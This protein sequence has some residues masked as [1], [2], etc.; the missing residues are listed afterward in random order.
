MDTT[1]ELI[2]DIRT[3]IIRWYPFKNDADIIYI[4]KEDAIFSFL[5]E[6]CGKHARSIMLSEIDGKLV[7]EKKEHKKAEYIVSIA[8]PEQLAKPELFFEWAYKHLESDGRLIVGMNNRL[9][10]RYFCGDRDIYTSQV[11]DGI[12]DYYRAYRSPDDKFLGRSFD[13]SQIKKMISSSGFDHNKFYS[14]YSDLDNAAFIF[15]DSYKPNEELYNRIIPTYNSP[16][17]LFLE[18]ERLYSSMLDNELFHTM[19]NAFLIECSLDGAHTDALQITSS[20]DRGHGEAMITVIHDNDTVTKQAAFKE[21]EEG[22]KKLDTNIKKLKSRGVSVVE[23]KLKDGIYTMPLTK[24]ETGAK[25][26]QR[27]FWK[28]RE[29]FLQRLDEFK[30]EIYKSSDLFEGKYEFPVSENESEADRLKRQKKRKEPWE[31]EKLSLLKEG[32]VDMIPLN[33][34]FVDGKFVFFDQEF[35]LANYP[36]KAILWRVLVSIYEGTPREERVISR[37]DLF[38]RYGLDNSDTNRMHFI[39]RIVDVWLTGL[40]KEKNLFDYH[41][42]IRKDN[43]IIHA[44]RQRMNYS[45]DEYQ[46][47]FI[48]T[49]DRADSRKLILFGSGIFARKFLALYG[50]DYDIYAVIDNNKDRWGQ[51]VYPDGFEETEGIEIMPPSVLE[52]F[53]PGEYKVLICIKNFNSVMKQLDDM[54]ISE[55]SVF[56]PTKAYPVKRHPLSVE[57]VENYNNS[58]VAKGIKKYHVGYIAGVFDLYHIGHLNMFRRAKEMCDYL[59]VGVLSDEGV[60]HQKRTE[61]FVPFAE[62]IEMVKSCR[63]VDE[64]VEI[65]YM[66]ARTEDAFK[67]HHFDVQFSGSD[68][69]NDP[70]FNQY[71]KYLESHGA[72]MEFFPYTQSTSST[73]LKELIEKKLI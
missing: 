60:L 15:A 47:L 34:F 51:K 58:T 22:L 62:R 2:N 8:Y 35:C 10:I 13:K 36:V 40:R 53:R 21:G 49:F 71:K 29:L 64:A 44:N 59:I 11:L 1:Q 33:T 30:N 61:P 27:I 69:V 7:S 28:D 4:G 20:L 52:N 17:A 46:K 32:F 37:H 39:Q 63:Y 24:A 73:R 56:D 72:T 67:M 38:L 55:Y 65:P 26:L 19:A 54:G 70:G 42:K 41:K 9:G 68:Y 14:V 25:Y 57:S 3:S 45:V 5:K 50:S 31:E 18:E 66:Y 16:E 6:K 12:D 43:E 23:G 48:D